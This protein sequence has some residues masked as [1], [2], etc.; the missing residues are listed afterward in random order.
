MRFL[1]RVIGF[2]AVATGFVTLII[3]GTRSLADSRLIFTP[4]SS[5]VEAFAGPRLAAFG[6]ALQRDVHP[7]LWDP[8]V[9]TL[10]K[11]P[12]AAVGIGLGFLFLRVGQP[13][14]EPIGFDTKR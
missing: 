4:L 8:V 10:L 2:L 1:L 3:D 13:R 12:L 7:L 14:P 6:A 11:L 5:A 9:L